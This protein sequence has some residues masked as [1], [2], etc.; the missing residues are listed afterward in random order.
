MAFPLYLQSYDEVKDDGRDSLFRTRPG[1]TIL[2]EGW[3]L[4]WYYEDQGIELY[5]LLDDPIERINIAEN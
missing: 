2:L 5:Y 3:K 4:H 1:S